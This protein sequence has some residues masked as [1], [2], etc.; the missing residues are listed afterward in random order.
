MSH[1]PLL[2]ILLSCALP[3]PVLAVELRWNPD[4]IDKLVYKSAVEADITGRLGELEPGRWIA[5]PDEF[6]R[7][8]AKLKR[9]PLKDEYRHY[10]TYPKKP[11]NGRGIRVRMLA[12]MFHPGTRNIRASAAGFA[13]LADTPYILTASERA[14]ADANPASAISLR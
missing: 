14:G 1:L 10:R 12:R 6:D 5:D 2:I 3:S 7:I 9:L 13:F 11:D 4:A 8:I